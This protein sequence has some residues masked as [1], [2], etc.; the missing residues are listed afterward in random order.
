MFAI[1]RNRLT[2][3]RLKIVASR[4][5]EAL[6]FTLALATCLPTDL[7][8]WQ[9]DKHMDSMPGMDMSGKHE[10]GEMG[11]SMAAMAGHMIMTNLR[12]QQP[13]DEEKV[14]IVIA[15][16]KALMVR[17]EDYRKALAD[18]YFIANPKAEQLQY[19][20]MNKA[21]DLAADE[22]FD[23]AKPTA[24]LYRKTPR[25]MYKLEGVMYTAR[26]LASEDELNQRLPLSIVRWHQ[27]TN[28]CVAPAD[29]AKE[30]LGAH[31]KFGMFGSIKTK[32]ACDAARGNFFPYMFN[33]M[34]HVFPFEKD[35][36]DI[37]SMNDD[38]P[39]VH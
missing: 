17:Y 15:E 4:S 25:K 16:A 30:Y 32:E 34:V 22:S 8:A 1:I 27:H 5:C 38:V 19:H 6:V 11:P 29:R 35:Y 31:P 36:K 13:G 26:V 39:H 14:K 23:P 37:F 3:S 28:F 20:F 33:W 9:K 2:L 21:N 12:P 10:V 24:L 7:P 18:G